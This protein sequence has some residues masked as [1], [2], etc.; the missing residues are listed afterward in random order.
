MGRATTLLEFGSRFRIPIMPL[1]AAT[2]IGF[3]LYVVRSSARWIAVAMFGFIIGYASWISTY[4]A[5][6]QAR[7]IAALQGALKPYV[8]QTDGYTVAVVPFK[9]FE[10]ELT[11]NITSTWPVGL[12][13]RLWVVSVDPS[14]VYSLATVATVGRLLSLR[15]KSAVLYDREN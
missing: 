14:A 5:I 1:A 9:R 4:T 2:T 7:A 13:K 6:E 15:Y 11:A 8:A 10:T 12:E 3:M